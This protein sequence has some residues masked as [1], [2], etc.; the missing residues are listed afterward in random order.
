MEIEPEE[1]ENFLESFRG[2]RKQILN[3]PGCKDL[4]FWQEYD[5]TYKVSTFSVWES[6]DALE[7]YRVSDLFRSTWAKVKP[8]FRSRARARSYKEIVV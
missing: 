5:Q 3:F 1:L 2:V 6:V 7:A 4:E 8:L